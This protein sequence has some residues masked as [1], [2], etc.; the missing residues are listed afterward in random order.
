M[1]T[2]ANDDEKMNSDDCIQSTM[3]GQYSCR[4]YICLVYIFIIEF[5]YDLPN[6]VS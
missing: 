3:T 6:M 5:V 1:T 2:D 4:I